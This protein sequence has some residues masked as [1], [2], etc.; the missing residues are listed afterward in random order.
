[1]A[2]RL[3]F[4]DIA[5]RVTVSGLAGLSV[6]GLY[7][8]FRVHNETMKAGEEAWQKKLAVRTPLRHSLHALRNADAH[9]EDT[10]EDAARQKELD[11]PLLKGFVDPPAE[12]PS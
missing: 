10:Q 1:M 6:Y 7:G 4:A 3:S 11:D 5:H 2:A 12:R 8:M 9:V